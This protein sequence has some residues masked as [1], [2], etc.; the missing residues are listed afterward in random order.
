MFIFR[1]LKT[2]KVFLVLRPFFTVYMTTRERIIETSAELFSMK[3]CKSIT[4]DDISAAN[5][6]SKRTLYELFADKSAL[7]EACLVSLTERM[8]QMSMKLKDESANILEYILSYQDYESMVSEKR[9]RIFTEEMRKFYPEV[10]KRTIESVKEKQ[11]QYTKSLIEEGINDGLFELN[12]GSIDVATKILA[13]L[14]TLNSNA[15]I[16]SIKRDSNRKEIFLSS[17]VVFLK[18]LST[19]K[20]REVIDNYYKTRD[21]D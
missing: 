2:R 18:G 17:V 4:M 14:V 19:E 21:I 6:I 16:D 10:Y 12:I 9:S 8:K 1:N 15:V 3:G 13:L 11:L 7:L 20:G 5:G